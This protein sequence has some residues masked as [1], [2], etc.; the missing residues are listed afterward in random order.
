MKNDR[1]EKSPQKV[2]NISSRMSCSWQQ[3]VAGVQL[4]FSDHS[5]LVLREFIRKFY[6]G[7]REVS[8]SFTDLESVTLPVGTAIRFVVVLNCQY[9]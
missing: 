6:K 5:L 8:L 3:V 4:L 7:L 2:L 9:V 1:G